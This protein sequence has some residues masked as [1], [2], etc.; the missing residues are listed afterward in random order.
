MNY[1]IINTEIEEKTT[2]NVMQRGAVRRGLAMLK[3]D[4]EMLS[5]LSEHTYHNQSP[6]A[7]HKVTDDIYIIELLADNNEFYE[8][9]KTYFDTVV[10]S[11]RGTI[12]MVSFTLVDQMLVTLGY[13][14][15]GPNSQ[16][17]GFA[18]KMLNIQD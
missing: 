8:G 10:L 17:A 15:D 5:K 13:I 11:K 9:H 12:S 18:K 6:I 16:F 1:D 14:Y 4:R 3:A 7:Y 2:L